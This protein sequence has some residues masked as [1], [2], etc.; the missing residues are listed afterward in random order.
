MIP[1]NQRGR[2]ILPQTITCETNACGAISG[3]TGIRETGIIEPAVA[4]HVILST[5][6]KE[7]TREM[8]KRSR[9]IKRIGPDFTG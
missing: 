9:R 6:I 3:A 1:A 5:P 7:L 8:I 2:I 4:L